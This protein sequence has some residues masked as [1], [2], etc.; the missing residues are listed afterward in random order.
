MIVQS[1]DYVE[2]RYYVQPYLTVTFCHVLVT[3]STT[4]ATEHQLF[5]VSERSISIDFFVSSYLKCLPG[6]VSQRLCFNAGVVAG[7]LARCRN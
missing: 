5:W 6:H 4:L 7:A 2:L 3:S 1:L